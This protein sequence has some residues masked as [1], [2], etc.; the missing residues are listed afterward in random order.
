VLFVR[1]EQTSSDI[2]TNN[3]PVKLLSMHADMIQNGTLQCR[4]GW[5]ELVEAM[6]EPD[7][8]IHH[9]QWEDVK[10]WLQEQRRDDN[11]RSKL[12]CTVRD[13]YLAC[14]YSFDVARSETVYV[15]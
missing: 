5:F 10:L 6:E 14:R 15:Y 8:T 2:L 1:S 13:E 12:A 11:R 7:E 4:K 3:V 9:V